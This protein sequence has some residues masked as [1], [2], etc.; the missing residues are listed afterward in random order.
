VTVLSSLPQNE[1]GF[2]QLLRYPITSIRVLPGECRWLQEL[3]DGDQST[4]VKHLGSSLLQGLGR[5]LEEL[6]LLDL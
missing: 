5:E 3:L 1:R 2:E 6:E 4:Q